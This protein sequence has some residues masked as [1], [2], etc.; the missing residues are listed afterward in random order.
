MSLESL[1]NPGHPSFEVLCGD[2]LS[3]MRELPSGSFDVVVTSPPYNIRNSTGNG[4]KG[5]SRK[6]KWTSAALVSGYTDHDD[7][8]PY[9]EYVAWQR[10]C[11]SEMLRLV[12]ETGAVFYNHKWRVQKGLLQDRHEIVQGFPVRQILIWQRNGGFNFN[13]G[14]FL[15][16]YEVVY[17]LAKPKFRLKPESLAHGDVWK[18][19]QERGN[20]HP[21][22]FPEALVDRI[23]SSVEA[24]RVLDPFC[25]SGTTG[26]VALRKGLHFV[27]MDI[28]P[29]YCRM[30]KERLAVVR[31]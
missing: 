28:S 26:V 21:A 16:T 31:F 11:L 22:P 6:G 1:D 18:I 9:E 10:D 8:M 29:T 20:P 14:Y 2:S 17:L 4:L 15:P 30:A 13:P 25:G 12:P 19:P 7:A 3:L 5:R 24:R 23:L 27:G